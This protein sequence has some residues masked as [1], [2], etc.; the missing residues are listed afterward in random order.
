MRKKVRT[1]Q[2]S[3]Y[4]RARSKAPSR[5]HDS[6]A[7]MI[8]I[9][10]AQVIED[11]DESVD[12]SRSGTFPHQLKHYGGETKDILINAVFFF[13]VFLLNI[14]GYPDAEQLVAWAGKSFAAATKLR[15]GSNY[16]GERRINFK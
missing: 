7:E 16:H 2:S 5:N 1:G 8:D 6:D 10:G 11:R 14:H 13:R 9:D 3:K 12:A 4:S 15:F